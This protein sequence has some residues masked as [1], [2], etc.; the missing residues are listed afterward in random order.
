L[1]WVIVRGMAW[2][3]VPNIVDCN[4]GGFIIVSLKMSVRRVRNR[5]GTRF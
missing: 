1:M 4:C 5:I 3:Q 2:V